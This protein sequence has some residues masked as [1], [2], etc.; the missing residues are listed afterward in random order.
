MV[1][2]SSFTHVINIIEC[3]RYRLEPEVESSDEFHILKNGSLLLPFIQPGLLSTKE[4]C[5]E[6]F[7]HSGEATVL[8]LVCFPPPP[9]P[10]TFWEKLILIVYPIGK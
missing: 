7:N 9:P 4:Y 5:L 2:C 10:L 8:P 6:T 3:F 1:F